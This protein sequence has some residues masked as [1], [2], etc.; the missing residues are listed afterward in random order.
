MMKKKI[1]Q[2]AAILLILAEMIIACGKEKEEGNVPYISCDC[3]QN[4]DK[5]DF[6]IE[7]FNGEAIL[8]KDL[9]PEQSNEKIHQ[10]E[11]RVILYNTKTNTA[12]LYAHFEILFQCHICNFPDFAE[13]W[14]IPQK[15]Q[16][17]YYS[18]T[19]YHACNPYGYTDRVYT[20]MVL[21]TFKLK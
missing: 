13:E 18:G 1:L 16:K 12:V 17:V 2:I 7:L 4:R 15:G 19:M 20:D 3:E 10:S 8:F 5:I 9:P 14:N 6:G 11:S 21:T